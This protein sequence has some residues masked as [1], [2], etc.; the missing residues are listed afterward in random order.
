MHCGKNAN[1]ILPWKLQELKGGAR[2]ALVKEDLM[3]TSKNPDSNM[4]PNSVGKY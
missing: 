1:S 3:T 2:V 4:D